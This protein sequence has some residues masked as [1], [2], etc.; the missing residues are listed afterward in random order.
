MY[1][2]FEPGPWSNHGKMTNPIIQNQ[3]S[4]SFVILYGK[5]NILTLLYGK[6]QR[7]FSKNVPDNFA[8]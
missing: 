1:F 2:V 3:V 8:L 5:V 7:N 6:C 4:F